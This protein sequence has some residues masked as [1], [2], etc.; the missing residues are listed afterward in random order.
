MIRRLLQPIRPRT[1][2]YF[3][4]RLFA[5][6]VDLTGRA[7]AGPTLILAPHADDEAIGCGALIARR[8]AAGANVVIVIAT[9]GRHSEREQ[10]IGADELARVRRLEAIEA[11]VAMGL[12]RDSVRFLPFEDG[13]LPNQ[14]AAL[15]TAIRE[16]EAELQPS[17]IFVAHT[18]EHPDHRTL[19][20]VARGTLVA[21][22]SARLYEYPVRYWT[23]VPWVT[24]SSNASR[25]L[26]EVIADPI[27]E[28]RRPPAMLIQTA[29][30]LDQ[31]HAAL[32][33]YAGEMAS[34][35]YFVYQFADQQYEAFFP[36][37]D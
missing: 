18:D 28:W 33:A 27:R 11:A 17:E 26:L 36:I 34:V 31:K 9:D 2:Q 7:T 19:N 22:T 5:R 32:A 24:R 25:A 23:R 35:G 37:R 29:G 12:G 3:R 4:N 20:E 14:R 21:A 15:S 6:G 13:S 10:E 1:A 16:I 30:Y 8:A